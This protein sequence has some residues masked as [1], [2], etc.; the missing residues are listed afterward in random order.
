MVATIVARTAYAA[1]QPPQSVALR[2]F[3]KK[4]FS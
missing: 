3:L 1:F 4:E 2:E